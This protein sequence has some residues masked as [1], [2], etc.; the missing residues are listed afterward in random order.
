M[1]LADGI[2]SRLAS[3]AGL[4]FALAV[5]GAC[6]A[7]T[8]AARDGTSSAPSASSTPSSPSAPRRPR[9]ERAG[10]KCVG[11][12]AIAAHPTAPC[13]PGMKRVDDVSIPGEPADRNPACLGIPLGEEACCL[14]TK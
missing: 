3:V 10:G 14:P 9:C 1:K 7:E 4:A 6:R 13:P 12:A 11:P 8:P 2:P 5:V